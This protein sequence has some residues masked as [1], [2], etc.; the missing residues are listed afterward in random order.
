MENRI[1]VM[2][3]IKKTLSILVAIFSLC[4][5]T[6]ANEPMQMLNYANE[7]YQKGNYLEAIQAY[8]AIL[9]NGYSST[10]LYHNLGNAYY[11]EDQPGYAALNFH[12][13]LRLSP[14]DQ[15]LKNNLE[16]IYSGVSA[17]ISEIPPVWGRS[18]WRG[19]QIA[20]G[21][22][23]WSIVGAF[24]IWAGFFFLYQW[25]TAPVRKVRKRGF[26]LGIL[27]IML[28][29]LPFT[30][31]WGAFQNQMSK[32]IAVVVDMPKSFFRA[33]D[34]RSEMIR[35]LPAG[36]TLYL[37]DQIGPWVKVQLR[38]GQSGWMNEGDFIKA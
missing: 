33:A 23:G 27:I 21:S 30:L 38:N 13:G 1:S 4:I 2:P 25:R 36:T 16:L 34:D 14:R 7:S 15:G 28:S 9:D 24:C 12:R 10:S 37:R 20:L 18:V 6:W 31:A 3:S 5:L 32:N 8:E 11:K 35:S 29:A 22:N 26:V 19:T 17:P